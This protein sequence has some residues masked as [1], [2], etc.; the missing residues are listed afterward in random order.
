MLK[1]LRKLIE[2]KGPFTKEEYPL[3][4]RYF[5]AIAEKGLAELAQHVWPFVPP[6]HRAGVLRNALEQAGLN[7]HAETLRTL[8]ALVPSVADDYL[9]HDIINPDDGLAQRVFASASPETAD[10]L[11]AYALTLEEPDALDL[12]LSAGAY[13]VK[14]KHMADKLLSLARQHGTAKHVDSVI[15]GL[16]LSLVRVV[17]G[18]ADE[19]GDGEE[20]MASHILRT[21]HREGGED[22]AVHALIE[23]AEQM[24]EF[25]SFGRL[26]SHQQ[27]ML[28]G[29]LMDVQMLGGAPLAQK[30]L[31]HDDYALV[32]HLTYVGPPK[33][34]DALLDMAARTGDAALGDDVRR[35]IA[36]SYMVGLAFGDEFR[37]LLARAQQ[38]K[39][40]EAEREEAL[41]SICRKWAAQNM[42]LPKFEDD[43]QMR[44]GVIKAMVAQG[45]LE[46]FLNLTKFHLALG[47]HDPHPEALFHIMESLR[48]DKGLEELK[49]QKNTMFVYL[50]QYG[51][52]QF[53]YRYMLNL[54]AQET[55]G[56]NA[57]HYA[58]ACENYGAIEALIDFTRRTGG[59]AAVDYVIAGKRVNLVKDA[60]TNTEVNFAQFLMEKLSP[61][62]QAKSREILDPEWTKLARAKISRRTFYAKVAAGESLWKGITGT[63]APHPSLHR[64]PPYGFKPKVYE[65]LLPYTLLAA[66]MENNQGA[67]INAY[68]LAVMFA[69]EEE[70]ERYLMRFAQQWGADKA[71]LFHDACLFPIPEYG[72]WTP[73]LWKG[74]LLRFGPAI[75]PYMTRAVDIEKYFGREKFP[76]TMED[77]RTSVARMNYTRS[78]EAPE[79]AVLAA[80]GGLPEDKFN[81]LLA[82]DKA[83]RKTHDYLPDVTVD[84]AVLGHP[85]FYLE[86]LP[87][88]DI[89]GYFLG[90]EDMLDCCQSIGNNGQACAEYGM[91]KP[92]Y[93]FYVWK[94]KTGGQKTTQ[95]R[96]V[97]GSWAWIGDDNML[98]F[99]SYEAQRSAHNKFMQVMLEQ[100][101]FEVTG[102][103]SFVDTRHGETI[104]IA[105]V[106]LG[107]GGKTPMLNLARVA[108]AS[109]PIDYQG[110]YPTGEECRDSFSQYAISPI[111][112]AHSPKHVLPAVIQSSDMDKLAE[113]YI[114]E[115]LKNLKEK[116]GIDVKTGIELEC[117]AVGKDAQ[118]TSKILDVLAVRKSIEVAGLKGR[119]EDEN[120]VDYYGQYEVATGVGAPLETVA[121]ANAL[122]AHLESNARAFGL[123]EF[124]FTTLP[125]EGKEA[126]SAHLSFSLWSEDGKPLFADADGNTTPFLDSV[127]SHVLDFQRVTVLPFAEHDNDYQRF[128]N[129]EWSPCAIR[130]GCDGDMGLTLRVAN[131]NN[132]AEMVEHAQPEN[133]R[134]ENRLPASS[135]SLMVA[136]AATLASVEYALEQ[137]TAGA[138]VVPI[139]GAVPA[140]DDAYTKE[141]PLPANRVEAVQLLKEGLAT[142][143]FKGARRELFTRLV[144][145]HDPHNVVA[146]EGNEKTDAPHVPARKNPAG[147]GFSA[148]AAA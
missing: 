143:L 128:H 54:L 41:F 107:D 59:Q 96:I 81:A 104:T 72:T 68:K 97:S 36:E 67:H 6:D 134:A 85:D 125:Y 116:Y 126:S 56:D 32:R 24:G 101:S 112:H 135:C 75:F 63:Q 48:E 18:K 88:G 46:D 27:N 82:W 147:A 35:V 12:V 84:G 90:N 148:A 15:S 66:K 87:A 14:F 20:G 2:G 3:L 26:G 77:M 108:R 1:L 38:G 110:T 33:L 43:A 102:K 64:Y 111:D 28:L 7:G 127:V 106:R 9:A 86:K 138:G 61:E 5:P 31:Q 124:L 4:A 131:A 34:N 16:P 13:Q 69:N 74:L 79:L 44:A 8:L 114:I 39:I 40:P 30:A 83:N 103:H 130:A 92:H 142:D 120:T 123:L 140:A 45:A 146:F 10:V 49:E 119:F 118:P 144:A 113:R 57:F 65:A 29:L 132:I 52:A 122:K 71:Q 95:D 89:R 37:E 80:K 129:T 100:F 47:E 58:A 98:V 50:L 21:I 70:A 51:E 99:D 42:Q 137:I 105:G 17:M 91:S 145:Q 23:T 117:Y 73:A 133:V 53:G 76:Q 136:M 141:Y 25:Y 109:K 139:L 60:A 94:Q 11:I 121:M 22:K 19:F 78:D 115:T 55:I 93:G 62:A